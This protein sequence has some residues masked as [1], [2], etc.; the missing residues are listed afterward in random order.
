MQANNYDIQMSSNFKT[1]SF[2]MEINAKAFDIL[3]NKIYTDKIGAIVRELSANAYDSHVD[4]GKANV[5]FEIHLPNRME[6]YFYIRDYGTGISEEKIYDV[7]IHTF[8]S[9]KTESNN[10]IGCMGLGSKTPFCYTDQFTIVSYY[11]GIQFC[12]FAHKD[13][14]GIPSISASPHNGTP[15]NEPNGLK[16]SF[17]V[18]ENSDYLTFANKVKQYL[19]YYKTAP[20]IIGGKINFELDSV[21]LETENFILND[22]RRKES[23]F[24]HFGRPQQENRILMGNIPYDI[25]DTMNEDLYLSNS[26]LIYKVDIGEIDVEASREAIEDVENNRKIIQKLKNIAKCEIQKRY[27]E[28]K[29]DIERQAECQWDANQRINEL[30]G[31]FISYGCVSPHTPIHQTSFKN[32]PPYCTQRLNQNTRAIDYGPIKLNKIINVNKINDG[33]KI[34]FIKYYN[35]NKIKDRQYK[36]INDN[37]KNSK[38]IIFLAD[39][40][41]EVIDHF[42]ILPEYITDVK[43]IPLNPA[44]PRGF[45]ISTRISGFKK[46]IGDFRVMN[47]CWQ[48]DSGFDMSKHILC[49]TK[50][51]YILIDDV[52]YN[53]ITIYKILRSINCD[54][55]IYGLNISKYKKLKSNNTF[56]EFSSWIKKTIIG[57]INSNKKAYQTEITFNSLDFEDSKIYDFLSEARNWLPKQISEDINC[58]CF[59]PSC[60]SYEFTKLHDFITKIEPNFKIP[61][62]NEVINGILK[63]KEKYKLIKLVEDEPEQREEFF[64]LFLGEK[65]AASN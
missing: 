52:A 60:Y 33:G 58:N 56:M 14:R 4:A 63:Y 1:K 39:K 5:P 22:W 32:I 62:K 51:S 55:T 38:S 25:P 43:D 37:F 15:T 2:G 44:K 34:I 10:F 48:A 23:S 11:N 36:W 26:N 21:I 9:D 3:V 28:I 65:N 7:Y 24:Q 20:N 57:H 18:T 35:D 61:L 46:L 45:N 12:Y 53:P 64:K 6:E 8:K 30:G 47:R 27:E 49:C 54:N 29:L 40:E 16:I 19:K 50:D 41:N 42:G 59:E 31:L 13:S 17:N